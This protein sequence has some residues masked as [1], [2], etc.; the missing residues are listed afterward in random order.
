M[1]KKK[2]PASKFPLREAMKISI[3]NIT[4]RV[5]RSLITSFG[6]I[7]GLAFLTALLTM[8]TILNYIEKE[9]STIAEYTWW[10]AGISMIVALVG[11]TN[12]MLM[13]VT[14]RTKEIGVYKTLGG[15]FNHILKMFLIESLILGLIG[16]FLGSLLGV[17]AGS[18]I[19]TIRFGL[20]K[21]VEALLADLSFLPTAIL[22][23]VGLGALSSILA[24]FYPIWRG[25]KLDPAEALR[26]EV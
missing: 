21:V 8:T 2:R 7:L 26:Y 3:E 18:L 5:S 4:K 19:Y 17:V 14:E 23:S 13:A 11:I 9:S 10:L 20:D 1:P 16:G 22:L 12:S 6:I 24:S 15:T 25:A